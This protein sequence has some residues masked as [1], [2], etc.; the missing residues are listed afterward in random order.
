MHRILQKSICD[1]PGIKV[2]HA[3]NEVAQTGC[4]VILPQNDAI[5]GMDVRGSAPGSREIE[6][7]RLVRLVNKIHAILLT[8][9][10]AYGLDAAG[11]VMQYLEEQDIGYETGFARVPIVPTSVIY[12]LGVGDPTIRPDKA[13]GYQAC[14]AAR[15]DFLAIGSV[16]VGIGATVGKILGQ[17]Y[18]M[19]AGIGTTSM[20]FSNGIIL[21]VLSVVNALGDIVSPKT[22]EIIAGARNPHGEGFLDTVEYLKTNAGNPFNRAPNN[23]TL[24]VIATNAMLS[25]EE[26]TKLAQIAQDGLALTIRPAHTMYDGDI[27]FV[28]SVGAKKMDILSLGVV[29]VECVTRSIVLAVSQ[30]D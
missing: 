9:G 15:A 29:A 24:V 28:L 5:A 14:Q 13:M 30:R 19:K 17:Q 20:T 10:S 27:V 11:G 26:A 6:T 2:G 22:G 23:T 7:L 8:G 1:V 18:A 4:T 3:Q 25:K 21:G 16:G 12:D